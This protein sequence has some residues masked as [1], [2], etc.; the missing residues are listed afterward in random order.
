MSS[1]GL[2]GVPSGFLLGTYLVDRFGQAMLAGSGGTIAA[3]FTPDLI[4]IGAAAGIVCGVLAMAGPAVRLVREGPLAS[5]ASA[6]GVQRARRIP[7]VAAARRGGDDGGRRRVLKIFARGSLPLDVGVNAMTLG[8]FGVGL[9]TI[10]IAPRGAGLLTELLTV[11][12]SDVGRLLSADVRRYALLFALSAGLLADGTSLAIAAHSMQLLGTEQI[13]AEKADRLPDA[14][15]IAT[16]IGTRSAGQPARRRHIR[17]RDRR[18][19]R[20]QRVFALAVDDLVRVVVAPCHRGDAG[21]L[22]QPSAVSADRCARH[23]LAGFAGRGH[24]SERDRRQPARRCRGR[25]RRAAHRRWA[26]A[27]S[28]GWDLSSTDGQ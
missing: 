8:M 11:A 2:L 15:L 28:G 19:R 23:F 21:R 6:G 10:W 12:R 26:E 9:V 4:A 22:V 13:A 3:H 27:L 18:G 25:H 17:T 20:A 7:I 5:M 24:R 16:P 14:L 1:A